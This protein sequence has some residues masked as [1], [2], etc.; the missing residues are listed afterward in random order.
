VRWCGRHRG[1][2]DLPP[3]HLQRSREV[4]RNYGNMSAASVMFVLESALQAPQAGNYL[5]TTVG[6]GFTASMILFQVQ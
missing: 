4:L 1:R 2:L 5:L 6:P 3:G